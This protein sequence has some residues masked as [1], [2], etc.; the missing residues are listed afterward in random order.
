MTRRAT[1]FALL[2][3]LCVISGCECTIG[4]CDCPP[5]GC[6]TC[7]PCAYR[8]PCPTSTFTA[9][10]CESRADSG[11]VKTG[12]EWAADLRSDDR[13]TRERAIN[14]LAGMGGAAIVHLDTSLTDPNPV[15]RY[16]ALQVLVRLRNE[17]WPAV[18]DV[19]YRLS[20]QDPAVRAEAAYVIGLTGC[21]AAQAIP[22]LICALNDTSTVVRYRAAVAFQHMNLA[23][24][25]GRA[26]LDRT[27][28]CDRDARVRE[29]ARCALYKLDKA[30]CDRP[31]SKSY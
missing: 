25:P 19:K 27:A 16:S 17:A 21:H 6:D 12:P 22:E 15:V 14:A 8:E 29:A 18:H 3:A 10:P 24:E 13:V 7:D 5:G 20:D 1:I 28:M 23:A 11:P 4:E 30:N 26:A 9:M 31:S 2:L